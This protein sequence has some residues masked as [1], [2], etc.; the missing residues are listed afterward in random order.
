M[1]INLMDKSHQTQ[2]EERVE[3][4]LI[5]LGLF[6][7]HDDDGY[8]LNEIIKNAR[9]LENKWTSVTKFEFDILSKYMEQVWY[10]TNIRNKERIVIVRRIPEVSALKDPSVSC[11]LHECKERY[12]RD[13]ELETERSRKREAAKAKQRAAS[14]K[15]A[16]EEEKLRAEKE[17]QLL[18]TLVDKYGIPPAI[19]KQS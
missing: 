8:A 13:V 19:T 9:V 11:I 15:K 5:A 2:V 16:A 7:Y 14:I 10:N 4:C 1:T 12:S 17:K 6:T 18:V 3:I